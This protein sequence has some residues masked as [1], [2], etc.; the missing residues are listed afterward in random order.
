VG[1]HLTMDAIIKF[2]ENLTQA[3]LD[4]RLAGLVSDE[5]FERFDVILRNEKLISIYFSDYTS[6]GSYDDLE[7][8][9]HKLIAAI[10]VD[11]CAEITIDA[12][13]DISQFIVSKSA[14]VA[15][16]KA[17]EIQ[18]RRLA[19]LR[20]NIRATQTETAPVEHGLHIHLL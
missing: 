2:N 4:R 18:R 8:L 20:Q 1:F 17:V 5:N 19:Q 7:A 15:R 16:E 14:K 3:Q 11:E 9:F 6:W 10:T 13:G 12:D